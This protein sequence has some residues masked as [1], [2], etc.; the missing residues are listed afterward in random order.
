MQGCS[1][2][3]FSGEETRRELQSSTIRLCRITSKNIQ[4]LTKYI[5]EPNLKQ[6]YTNVPNPLL[7]NLL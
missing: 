3:F 4:F 5:K 6:T 7:N 2:I 1:K